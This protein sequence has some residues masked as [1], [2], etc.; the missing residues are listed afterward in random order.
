[1]KPR[2]LATGISKVIPCIL[3]ILCYVYLIQACPIYS[4][5]ISAKSATNHYNRHKVILIQIEWETRR[6][7]IPKFKAHSDSTYF[8]YG[9]FLK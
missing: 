2:R 5:V 1:M 4:G 8:I 9:F 7:K 6:F 3:S